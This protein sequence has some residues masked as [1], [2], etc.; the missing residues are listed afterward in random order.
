MGSTAVWRRTNSTCIY[1]HSVS[2]IVPFQGQHEAL[3]ANSPTGV[4]SS[5]FCLCLAGAYS[6]VEVSRCDEVGRAQQGRFGSNRILL[7]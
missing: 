3:R 7:E 1:Q 5:S 6:A 2:Q 4:C